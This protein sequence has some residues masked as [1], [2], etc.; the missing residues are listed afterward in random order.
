MEGTVP[1]PNGDIH[2]YMD[3]KTIK[4][5]ATEGKGYLTIQSRCQPKANMEK[6][7]WEQWRRFQEGYIGAFGLILRKKGL[8]PIVCSQRFRLK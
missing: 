1:T 5:K 7:I 8:L 4:V 3:N 6:P 2:V